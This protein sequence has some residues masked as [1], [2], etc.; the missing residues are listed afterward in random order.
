M[1]SRAADADFVRQAVVRTGAADN[2]HVKFPQEQR[3]AC[4]CAAVLLVV[5]CGA[6]PVAA[7][8]GSALDRALVL[9]DDGRLPEAE[10]ALRVLADAGDEAAV[11]ALADTLMLRGRHAEA[12]VLLKPRLA[13]RPQDA[14][15]AG[16]LARALDG[17][18]QPE[19]ALAAYARRLA[20]VPDDAQSAYRMADL[21]LARKD[22]VNAGAVAQAALKTHPEH[23]LLQVQLARSLLARGRLPTAL[24]S[25]L[26]ATRLAPQS[27]EAWL[28]LAQVL[29]HQGELDMAE[30]AYGK[31]LQLDPQH[32]EALVDLGAMLVDKGETTKALAVLKRAVQVAPDSVLAWLAI[33]TA[34]HR[35]KDLDGAIG[36]LEEAGRIQPHAPQILRTL[37]Q[38]ALDHGLPRRALAASARARD[39]LQRGR[40][41]AAAIE[42]MED[43]MVRAIVVL[44]LADHL[45]RRSHDAQA[46][47]LEI[48]R[49][50]N[51]H[52][53]QS[54]RDRTAGIA[55]AAADHVRAAQARCSGRRTP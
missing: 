44:A 2:F 9:R 39:L 33:A 6:A 43:L 5:A 51:G 11:H 45:C 28:V 53:L 18:G 3:A 8:S 31:C 34:R 25:A 54:P 35:E 12:V 55:A 16:L 19:A 37:A 30:I 15:V 7:P 36:A 27:P 42:E 13:A 47:Q 10:Q 48:D 17:A 50:I 14:E 26:K 22:Y 32:P 46:L 4:L 29:T 49:E 20:L 23:A 41:D 40:G 1:P 21:L 38:V 52:D 24:E